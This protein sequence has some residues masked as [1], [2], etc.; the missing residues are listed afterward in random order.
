MKGKVFHMRDKYSSYKPGDEYNDP[1][2]PHMQEMGRQ[3]RAQQA[4]QGNRYNSGANLVLPAQT[5]AIQPARALPVPDPPQVDRLPSV[6]DARAVV[7]GSYLDRA[8]GFNVKTAGLSTVVALGFVAV[9][10]VGFGAP[11]LSL[12]TLGWLAAGYFVTWLAAYLVDAA[13]SPEGVALFHTWRA[14]RWLDREQDHRHYVD[15]RTRWP[16]D[17]Q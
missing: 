11:F 6:V 10:V 1:S 9:G 5:T 17:W 2:D 4:A 15:E 13:A 16:E 8:H 3:L 7:S 14:W 12:A